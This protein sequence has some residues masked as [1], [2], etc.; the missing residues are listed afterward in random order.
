MQFFMRMRHHLADGRLATNLV[1]FYGLVVVM[2]MGSLMLRRWLTR[3]AATAGAQTG[4][5]WLR[6]LRIEAARRARA[7]LLWAT[8]IVVAGTVLAGVVYHYSGRDIRGELKVVLGLFTANELIRLAFRSAAIIGL[9]MVSRVGVAIV[10]KLGP[11]LEGQLA[12]WL[13]RSGSPELLKRWCLLL[14]RYGVAL[15]RIGGLWAATHVVRLGELGDEIIGPVVRLMTIVVL[16]RLSTIGFAALLPVARDVGDQYLAQ[17]R[18]R[19]YWERVTHMLTFGQRCFEAAVYVWASAW[20][21]SQV[22]FLTVLLGLSQDRIETLGEHVVV[23]IGILFATRALIELLQV[24]VNEAFGMYQEEHLIDQ[25]GRTL[26]P[27]LRSASQYALYFGAGLFM[28]QELG[29]PTAPILAG[30]GIVGLAVGLGAQSLVTDLVSGF[31]ILFE[32]QY[33]VGD[34]VQIGDASGIVE[35]V[36]IRLTEVRD[37]QGKLYIIPNGQIKTV[38]NYSKGYVNALVDWK[39]PSGSDLESV[40]RS[41]A[42]AGKRL[43][44]TRKEVLA[45]T[46]IQGLVD[47]TTSDMTIRAVTRVRPGR[48]IAMQNE[49]RRLLKELVDAQPIALRSAKAA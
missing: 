47:F 25:K 1:A 49:Y 37:Q 29:L 28:L 36:G 31:F 5:E 41:M 4:P 48:H 24:L 33:L 9:L 42:E 34:F 12:P 2:V 45:D 15:V 23:C 20:C 22:R 39:L 17:G 16:A 35:A 10:R 32:G 21:L 27:L 26:V 11:K 19:R 44:Q 40:F 7:M 3:R 6:T 13:G 30:A 38:V 8:V 18:L 43:R 14:E 46:E